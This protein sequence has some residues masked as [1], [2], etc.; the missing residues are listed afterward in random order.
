LTAKSEDEL[1]LDAIN[2]DSLSP[3]DKTL[4]LGELDLSPKAFSDDTSTRT[5]VMPE[6]DK[7]KIIDSLHSSMIARE[8]LLKG[9]RLEVGQLTNE[10]IL[11]EHP[12]VTAHAEQQILL[13]KRRIEAGEW[14]DDEIIEAIGG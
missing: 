6:D 11:N 13:N 8:I 9:F 14:T 3:E 10:Q 7:E 1:G 5:G 2:P 4:L 12:E